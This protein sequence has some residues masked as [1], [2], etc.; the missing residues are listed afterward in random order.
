MIFDFHTHI[1]PGID[2]GSRSTEMSAEML[3]ASA[4]QG[5]DVILTTPH[6][7]ADSMGIESFLVNRNAAL[8]KVRPIA[9][10][11]GIRLIPGGEVAFFDNM[12]RAEDLDRLCI[13]GT[14]YMLLEM[15]FRPW[16]SGDL[17]EVDHIIRRGI[18]PIIAHVERFFGFQRDKHIVEDLMDRE[19]VVQVNAECL[20]ERHTRRMG[21][22]LFKTGYAE[23]LGSDCHNLTSRRQNLAEGRKILQKKLGY[24]VLED[25][26]W[27][28]EQILRNV[29]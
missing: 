11:L 25:I 28:G 5:I 14:N 12:S 4:D 27:T 19:V 21:I 2:D 9:D 24:E 26:D 23:L 17:A 10:E 16:H 1:L 6:F 18:R 22:K 7:Y 13:E 29:L 3:S 8:E 20:I 15:P